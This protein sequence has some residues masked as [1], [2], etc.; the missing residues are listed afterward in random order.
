MKPQ[1]IYDGKSLDGDR[2]STFSQDCRQLA[3]TTA[4]ASTVAIALPLGVVAAVVYGIS[5]AVHAAKGLEG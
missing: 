3:R 2:P 4:I 5:E 1:I